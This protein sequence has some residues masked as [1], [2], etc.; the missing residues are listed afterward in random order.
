MVTEADGQINRNEIW[1]RRE[2]RAKKEG[3]KTNHVKMT[4][5]EYLDVGEKEGTEDRKENE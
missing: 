1:Q 3:E 4:G 5:G 2:K